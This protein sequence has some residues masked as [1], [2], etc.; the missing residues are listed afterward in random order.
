MKLIVLL[1]LLGGVTAGCTKENVDEPSPVVAATQSVTYV[2]DGRQYY[3]DPQSE[4]EWS[5]F[6]DRM[7]A[8]AAEG[9]YVQFWRTGSISQ[10]VAPKE[11]LTYVTTIKSES[12]AWLAEKEE[13][14]FIVTV[15]YNED[16]GEYT[17]TAI[18]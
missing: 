6:Y 16:T 7:L 4:E 15:S 14:G 1:A 13:E 10:T 8:L 17:C 11:K 12:L 9:H 5:E 2:V 18:R 3:A